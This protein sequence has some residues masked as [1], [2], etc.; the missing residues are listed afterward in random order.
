MS[1]LRIEPDNRAEAI[2]RLRQAHGKHFVPLIE[3]RREL[4]S[5]PLSPPARTGNA[6][7]V[8]RRR[9]CDLSSADGRVIGIGSFAIDVAQVMVNA[10]LE[11]RNEGKESK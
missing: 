6:G 5:S 9:H 10:D 7:C 4:P 3:G 2:A 8:A 1:N 11:R